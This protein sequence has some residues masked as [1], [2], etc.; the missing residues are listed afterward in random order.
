M[1][2][3]A[4]AFHLVLGMLVFSA[5]AARFALDPSR[6]WWRRFW[7]DALLWL[8]HPVASAFGMAIAVTSVG[9]RHSSTLP[10][11]AQLLW[12]L[13]VPHHTSDELDWLST[14]RA[15][16]LSQTLNAAVL[17]APMLHCG[18]SA[19]SLVVANAIIGLWA[20][21][22]HSNLRVRLARLGALVVS[23]AF[24]RH[25]HDPRARAKGTSAPCSRCGIGS[26]VRRGRRR[27]VRWISP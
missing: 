14:S 12:R 20:V 21:T 8:V 13:R 9:G 7:S 17:S 2:V 4:A 6:R 26:S 23:P 15:H 5:L 27:E 19:R 25:Q 16:P 1:I 22:V 24:H 10:A 18:L 3:C 11:W